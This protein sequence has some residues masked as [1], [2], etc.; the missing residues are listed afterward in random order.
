MDEW[1]SYSVFRHTREQHLWALSNYQ[2]FDNG[3]W[4]PIPPEFITDEYDKE[5][6][7]WIKVKKA[8]STYTDGPICKRPVK[9]QAHF[10]NAKVII[11]EINRRLK[12][13]KTD[14][15]LLKAQVQGGITEYEE[16][17]PEAQM[18]LNFISL[19]DFRKRKERYSL[20][21]AKRFWYY[22][23]ARTSLKPPRLKVKIEQPYEQTIYRSAKEKINKNLSSAIA[24]SLRGA[25]HGRHWEELVGFTLKK[26]MLHLEAKFKDDMSWDNYGEWHIDHIIPKS[27]FHFESSDDPEFRVCWGLA[28]LQPLWAKDN[29]SK[30]GTNRKKQFEKDINIQNRK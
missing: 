4:P 25:K 21:K 6:K 10:E 23:K 13:T 14:G 24:D 1:Y 28:N 17:E 15:K 30:G 19:W 20:W 5:S 18:A 26:L 29:I 11:G 2:C 3:D 16:L 12:L 9:K 22:G 27:R 8:R 7:K